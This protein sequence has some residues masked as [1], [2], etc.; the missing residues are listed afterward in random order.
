LYASTI[1]RGEDNYYKGK[2]GGRTDSEEGKGKGHTVR[3]GGRKT[4]SEEG[5]RTQ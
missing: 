3:R 2:G 4:D 1:E 5:R